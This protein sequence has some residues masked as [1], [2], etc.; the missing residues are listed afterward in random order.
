MGPSEL[1]SVGSY[2]N[3]FAAQAALSALRAAGIDATARRDDCG[4]LRPQLWLSGIDVMV[5]TE[6]AQRAREVLSS[7]ALSEGPDDSGG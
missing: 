4:G 3:D 5:R 7:E 2:L 6:D 1:E